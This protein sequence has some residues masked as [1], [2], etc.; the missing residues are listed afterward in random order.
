V[1][2]C[3]VESGAETD[4]LDPLH[5]MSPL[6]LAARN[7]YAGVARILLEGK[8]NHSSQA[9]FGNTPLN[10]A[11]IFGSPAV[12][13][14]LVGAK[15]DLEI[16]NKWGSAPLVQACQ[17]GQH[18]VAK[19]MLEA[20]AEKH[21]GD[22]ENSPL[23]KAAEWG[24]LQ[25]AQLLLQHG[26]N[27]EVEGG[28]R[29]ALSHAVKQGHI[30]ICRL[31]LE[32]GADP[33]STS[34]MWSPALISA[35][36][37]GSLELVELL[38]D[39]KAA[40]DQVD[41]NNYSRPTALSRAADR[42]LKDITD[43]LIRRGADVNYTSLI[44][45]PPLY[46]AARE[47]HAEVVELLAK[48]GADVNV[49]T[50]GE[51]RP[52]HVAYDFAHVVRVL[53]DNGADIN[54]VSNSGTALYLAAKWD[55]PDVVKVF[56]EHLPKPP[57]FEK[58]LNLE[59]ELNDSGYYD[60]MSALTIAADKGNSEIVRLLLEA[61]AN[62]NQ[63]TRQQSCA[64]HYAL[65]VSYGP[66]ENV[67]RVL[68][69]YNPELNL[70][71]EDGDTA[72]NCL[73]NTTPVAVIKLLVNAGADLEIRN[74]LGYTPLCR[75]I[76]K[77]NIEVVKYLISKK[78][79]INMVGGNKGGPLHLA[80]G[81]SN[82][83]LVKVLLEN[84][85]DI[86]LPDP[87]IAGTPLQSACYAKKDAED[88]VLVKLPIIN[89]LLEQPALDI[90]MFGGTFGFAINVACIRC[91]PETIKLLLEKGAAAD[92]E[93]GMGRKPIHLASFRT[94][95]HLELFL[96][97]KEHIND[98][99][100]L[101]RTPLHFAVSSGR[102]DLVKRILDLS[103]GS[104]DVHDL[105][106]WTPLMWA[107]R[108]CGRWETDSSGQIEVIKLLKECGANIYVRGDG[109]DRDWSPLKVAR[110][111]GA[112]DKVLDLLSPN[113]SDIQRLISE[114]LEEMWDPRFHEEEKAMMHDGW[115]CDACL[116]VCFPFQVEPA[117]PFRNLLVPQNSY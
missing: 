74:S 96:H 14:L 25:C 83:E 47:G 50:S 117:A 22:Q 39:H 104:V 6:N 16:K 116:L 65:S 76:K 110:Y 86:N 10:T 69:E 5:G 112:D 101:G 111:Y 85:G 44:D 61:G 8:A 42:G 19:I 27:T 87:G 51:W 45:Y 53:L 41:T 102:V 12:A 20:G 90:N 77:K 109:L 24:Y 68:L 32:N 4:P 52:I 38:L 58:G 62:V 35:V 108:I 26:A 43:C 64:L 107:S 40:V 7:N 31:L 57:N 114:G 56:L 84:G 23:I 63:R 30:D 91:T 15:A 66:Q 71:D 105:D 49:A 94:L 70:Q 34:E 73:D 37:R 89:H 13:Q 59:I 67:L 106:G 36:D 72:L 88:E 82:L 78:A 100:I 115:F 113:E 1:A 48:A 98:T 99:D 3:L 75:A 103:E 17:N 79:K 95:E 18:E 97:D 46:V 55:H 28:H 60:G 93:D 21:Y 29:T 33:N 80:C 92:V 2:K 54:A 9:E 11:C 81:Q